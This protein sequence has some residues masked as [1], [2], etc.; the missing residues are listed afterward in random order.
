MAAP[1]GTFG[2][3][4]GCHS[5]SPPDKHRFFLPGSPRHALATNPGEKCERAL[6]AV[7]DALNDGLGCGA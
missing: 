7:D 4:A 1:H 2:A 3:A 5:A 6:L